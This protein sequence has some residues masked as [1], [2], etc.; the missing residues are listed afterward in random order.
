MIGLLVVGVVLPWVVIFWGGWICYRVLVQNGKMLQQVDALEG[1]I[2]AYL[3]PAMAEEPT[4]LEPGTTAPAFELPELR[5]GNVALE[6]FRGRSVL[7]VFFSTSCSYC[8]LMAPDLAALPLDGRDRMPVPLV[9]TSSSAEEMRGF[10]AKHDIKCS[11]LLELNG[12]TSGRYMANGT[13]TGYL[14]DEEGTIISELAVGA[15]HLMD[16]ATNPTSPLIKS[17]QNMAY[18]GMPKRPES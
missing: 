4:G 11:V 17:G 8:E 5:G 1:L 10:V 3:S 18:L 9:V 15:E 13:P 12:E 2:G 7:L 16:L 14:I 6:Q